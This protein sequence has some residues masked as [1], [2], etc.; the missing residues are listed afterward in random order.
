MSENYPPKKK[1]Y[2]STRLTDIANDPSIGPRDCVTVS[3]TL[4]KWTIQ[5]LLAISGRKGTSVSMT[6]A[7]LINTSEA[8]FKG[9]E[10]RLA[11]KGQTPQ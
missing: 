5:S 1:N 7:M 8:R 3:L 9:S 2:N 4:Q 10:K 11:M 6:V